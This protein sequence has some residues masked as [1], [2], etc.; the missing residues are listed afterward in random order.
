[1]AEQ[2]QE[3]WHIVGFPPRDPGLW[4]VQDEDDLVIAT[5]RRREDADHIVTDHNAHQ[6]TAEL[7]DLVMDAKDWLMGVRGGFTSYWDAHDEEQAKE[8]LTRADAL[9]ARTAA[10]GEE[11]HA[12][13]T[14]ARAMDDPAV[15][16]GLAQL[17]A[18]T[19]E[20]A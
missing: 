15:R 13:Y 3:Q 10:T 16:A 1:M 19:R 8:W 9:L 18:A 6:D 20:E 5:C 4:E 14:L 2:G 17:D 11:A 12:T 7:A